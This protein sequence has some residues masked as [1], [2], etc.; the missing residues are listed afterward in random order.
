MECS[1]PESKHVKPGQV[2]SSAED[3][4]GSQN[5]QGDGDDL[6]TLLG[7]F[8]SSM[9]GLA[10]EDHP[11]LAAHVEGGQEGGNGEQP[12]DSRE[13][14]EGISQDLVLRPEPSQ[15]EDSRQ[16][17]CTDQVHPEGDRH[18]LAQPAHVA[19]IAGVK[20]LFLVVSM[21]VM[22]EVMMAAFQAKDYRTSREE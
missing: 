12:V 20:D 14:V 21:L 9:A 8:S 11:D 3:R 15:G 13:I 16:R 6:W 1:K 19:H 17:Q 2:E 18:L 10:K 5:H 22:R 4:Q 7:M